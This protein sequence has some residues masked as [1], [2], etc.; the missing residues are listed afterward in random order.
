MANIKAAKKKIKVIEKKTSI[1]KKRKSEFKTYIRKFDE[2][3][4]N[5]DLDTAKE[6][7]K[8]IEKKIDKAAAKGIM[9]KNTAA[10]RISSLTK[11]LNEA[12]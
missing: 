8:L 6:L 2:A 10:R 3:L 7:L 9:H 1:N 12:M 5:N 4:E 11:K